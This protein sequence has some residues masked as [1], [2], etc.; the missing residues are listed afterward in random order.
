MPANQSPQSQAIQNVN[1]IIATAVQLMQM[2]ETIQQIDQQWTDDNVASTIANWQTVPV[3]PDGSLGT[4]SDATINSAH[5]FNPALYPTLTRPVS[6]FQITQVKTILDELVQYINGQAI[7]Q[8]GAA[9]A[10][11]DAVT[12]G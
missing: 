9:R 7:A 8:Q 10:V 2:Y 4:Q 3:A 5:P 11:L 1:L 6:A 12:G